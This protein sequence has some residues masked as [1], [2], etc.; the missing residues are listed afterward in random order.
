MISLECCHASCWSHT[1]SARSRA[2]RIQS[3]LTLFEYASFQLGESCRASAPLNNQSASDAIELLNWSMPRR[4]GSVRRRLRVASTTIQ[5][6]RT[7]VTPVSLHTA[8]NS[9]GSQCSVCECARHF[10]DHVDGAG[11]GHRDPSARIPCLL[12]P[13]VAD[14]DRLG[15]RLPRAMTGRM[16]ISMM[17]SAMARRVIATP[18]PCS[19]C[20]PSTRLRRASPCS[21][22][23]A[24]SSPAHRK[25]QTHSKGHCGPRSL[26]RLQIEPPTWKESPPPISVEDPRVRAASSRIP[27]ATLEQRDR[28]TSR[29]LSR[30]S[31]AAYVVDTTRRLGILK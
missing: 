30:S 5:C 28:R 7:S 8:V 18:S 27:A 1:M 31:Q 19:P 26:V 20:T 13:S 16:P 14:G 17:R 25:P 23:R 3:D 6:A 12:P 15:A 22:R 24:S 9:T 11:D 4:P 2:C 21:H 10:R 29:S